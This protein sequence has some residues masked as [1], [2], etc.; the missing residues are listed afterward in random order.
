MQQFFYSA[1][2]I[3]E[4]FCLGF[5]E[6]LILVL[7]NVFLL[8]YF[9]LPSCSCNSLWEALVQL[10]CSESVDIVDPILSVRI[11]SM[12][13]TDSCSNLRLRQRC[14]RCNCSLIFRA[15]RSCSSNFLK[16][17]KD[18]KMTVFTYVKTLVTED[19]LINSNLKTISNTLINFKLKLN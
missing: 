16:G 17:E 2:V 14:S 19:F 4:Q 1:S 7:N 9:P 6:S 15:F 8:P 10:P 3:M 13:C 11:R 5:V 18:R 12:P